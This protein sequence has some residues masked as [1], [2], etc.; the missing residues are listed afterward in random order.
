M[1]KRPEY[2]HLRDLPGNLREL[3]DKYMRVYGFNRPPVMGVR[4]LH[5]DHDSHKPVF[6]ALIDREPTPEEKR[7]L[8]KTFGRGRDRFT[9]IYEEIGEL[10]V[11]KQK[12]LAISACL[13]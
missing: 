6:K 9:I 2:E 12:Q 4:G 10:K 13:I 8:H 7:K 5:T 3:S 1:R 11:Q